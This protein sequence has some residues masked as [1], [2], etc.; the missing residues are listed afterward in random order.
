[1]G[2]QEADLNKLF[3]RAPATS[4]APEVLGEL[5]SIL[6]LHALD[7]QELSYKWE[8]YTMKMGPDSTSRAKSGRSLNR[9]AFA[10]P[11]GGV[12]GDDVFGKL[13]GMTPNTPSQN[14]SIS[15]SVKRKAANETPSVPKFSKTG[16][17]RS[18]TEG[19]ANGT[20][21]PPSAPF[22]E[23]QNAGQI[24]E[25]LNVQLP[26]F[27]PPVA[28]PAEPRVKLTANTDL[29]KFYYKPLAMHLSE[30]SEVL[31][32]RIDEFQSLV[33]TAHGLEDASFGSAASQSTNEI[34]AVGRIT[35]DTPE[36]KLNAASIMLESSRRSGAGLRVLLHVDSISHEFFPGQIVAL[37][38]INASG[39][40]FSVNEVLELPL[41]PQA[42]TAVSTFEVN[43]ERLGVVHG[44]EDTAGQAL[45][46]MVASGP[47]TADDNLAFEPLTALCE[48]AAET[49]ADVLII[50]GPILDIEHPLLA[51]GDFD[52]PADPSLEPDQI[53]FED[54]FRVLVGNQLKRLAQQVPSMTIVMVPSV[55]D[56]VNKHVSWPQEPFTKQPLG[57]PKQV[58]MVTNPV[59][60]SLNEI[61]VGISASD[62]LSDLRNEEVI[63]GK[64]K[65][66]SLLSRLPKHL[67]RQ[68]HFYPIFPPSDR[69]M[70]PK[71][72]TQE[73]LATGMPLDTSYLKLGEWL[74]V[75][76]DLLITPSS[77]P[78]FGK[79]V[80]GVVVIN[81]GTVSKRRG[82]GTYTQLTVHPR[83]LT[84]EELDSS[85]VPPK[86]R[87]GGATQ[88]LKEKTPRQSALAK[89]N[90]ITAA[91]EAEIK[92]SF[93]IFST[94]KGSLP[95]S[96]FRRALAALNIP[97]KSAAE[98]EE[99]LSAADPEDEGTITYANFVAI[100]ALKLNA[101]GDDDERA[102][103]SEAFDLFL[104]MGGG[105]EGRGKGREGDERITM[106]MLK[107]IAG[108]LKED[109]SD[110]LLRNMMME[111][112]GGGGVGEGVDIGEFEGVMRRVRKSGRLYPRSNVM[113]LQDPSLPPSSSTVMEEKKTADT[114]STAVDD[115][116]G[117][118]I[119]HVKSHEPT[120]SDTV[121][122]SKDPA[123]TPFIGPTPKSKP[124]PT[125]S[126]TPD[127]YVKYES[128]LSMATSWTEVAKT[129]AS[130][131]S[132]SPIKDS[133][134]MWLTREC[135]LR[136]LRASKWVI[137]TAAKRLQATLTWRREWGLEEHTADYISEE[138]ETGK[139]VITGFDNE[140]R[141]CL[142][143]NPH[144]QNTK[145]EKKQMHHLVF[146]LERC[147]DLMPS[148]QES[149]AL[150]VNYSECRQGQNG[151]FSQAKQTVSIL[152]N[153]YPERLGIALVQELPF[154][155][156]VFF[157]ALKWFI[158]P[159]TYAKLHFNE[160]W[161]KYIPPE[162]LIRGYGGVVNFEYEHQTYWP[163]FINLA[164]SR[165]ERM[166]KVWE[167]RGKKVGESEIHL[168][169]G[170]I[171]KSDQDTSLEASD[172]KKVGKGMGEADVAAT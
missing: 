122:G 7:P 65:D 112:N 83:K 119:S 42:A 148:G 87:G 156:Q 71:A 126:L 118:P 172:E 161:T 155:I 100:A 101:R 35:C 131:P 20:R 72:E 88:T 58:R 67:I 24:T 150:F 144:R 90:G 61:V 62:V 48:R 78:P 140:G 85:D 18:P 102:E 70:L 32:D 21:L 34:I 120:S 91:T 69:S 133:E 99:L 116:V 149:L 9:K 129:S 74:S 142:Y 49:Y 16:G 29:R 84:R 130:R 27:E 169:S 50:I 80:E 134:R 54:I 132:K 36:G 162:Q 19:R 51:S 97:P 12:V 53:T 105:G 17:K 92:E 110:D 159:V 33:Q 168:R 135:L 57:L 103:V 60:I 114:G 117:Y 160:D 158:D 128:L 30:A 164:N 104:K 2:D 3:V 165:R 79:V 154:Y 44:N 43:N 55:R 22:A 68:R 37:R 109:V 15:G 5:Q 157:K 14:R 89:E 86:R 4:L 26:A 95:S 138:N 111:A 115:N 77:L 121:D 81:P 28:P 171:E 31:D 127:Q 52:I 163:S 11:R 23:R 41:P 96:S 151:S 113:S 8:E 25:T 59:V 108:L 94:S 46:I 6:R 146:M 153:H 63:V 47:Y 75:M 107:N 141:P 64:P 66:S 137:N 39:S 139:Q 125:P 123:K 147:I 136:Y 40:Y 106:G 93:S 38:G 13:E 56:A 98:Y 152:Q 10:T 167:E 82:P 45:S 170:E 143:L 124:A 1:M 145:D 73:S 76:P 166:V